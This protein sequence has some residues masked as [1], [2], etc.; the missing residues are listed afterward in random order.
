VCDLCHDHPSAEV[1]RIGRDVISSTFF[2][3]IFESNLHI[4][5]ICGRGCADLPLLYGGG[6]LPGSHISS[7]G[8]TCNLGAR[9]NCIAHAFWVG[10]RCSESNAASGAEDG[11]F[12]DFFARRQ[13][14]GILVDWFYAVRAETPESHRCISP[15]VVLGKGLFVKKD[16]LLDSRTV[17]LTMVLTTIAGFS[18]TLSL[19]AQ[20]TPRITQSID[21]SV[22]MRIAG[23]AHPL[24]TA[25]NDLGRASGDLAME[26]MILV[27]KPSDAQQTALKKLIDSQ[28]DRQSAGYH[29]WLAPEQYGAQF[30]SHDDD[31]KTV[32]HWL[33]SQGF[34][35][36]SVARGKQWI[37][38][39]GT[40]G[41]VE[42]AFH[43][44]MHHYLVGGEVH[45]ANA[46]D[47]SLPAALAPVV[48]GVL[49]L[50]DFTS[51]PLLGR[52]M[53]VH[54][55]AGTGKLAP[56]YTG[57]NANGTFHVVVPGDYARIYNTAPLLNS[58]IDGTGVSIAIVGRNNV[59]LSDLQTFRKMF[60]LPANDPQFIFNGED[61]GIGGGSDYVEATLDLEWAAAIAPRATIKFVP[62]RTTFT[63][64]GVALSS[65]YIVDNRIA[66]IMSSSF[67]ACEAFL[68]NAGNA[69][70]RNLYQ[71]AAA[72]GIS[73][74]VATGD[75]GVAGCDF[76]GSNSSPA[77]FGANVS[78]AASTPFDTAVGGTEFAENGL[79]GIYWLPNNRL[80]QSSATGYIPEAVWNESCDPTVD[81]NQCFGTG[82]YTIAGSGGGPSN[83]SISS[84]TNFVITCISGTPKPS[85]QAGIGVPNDG[86]R[87]IPDLAMAAAAGHDPLLLCIAGSCQTAVVGGQTVIENAAV[88]GGTSAAAPAMAGVMALLE[89][90]NGTFQGLANYTLY[91]LAAAENLAHC[92]SSNLTDPLRA[93]ACVFNDTTAGDNT[94]PGQVGYPAGKGYDMST[95]LGSVNATNLVS[96]WGSA[97]K[98]HSRSI[99]ELGSQTAKHG[100]PIPLA[101]LVTPASG[102]GAPSGDFSLLSGD[103]AAVFGGTLTSGAFGGTVSDLPGGHYTLSAHYSGDAM[104]SASNSNSVEIHISPEESV[105]NPMLYYLGSDGTPFAIS[106]NNYHV[107]Y[108][109]PLGM[110]VDVKGASGTGAPTGK[111]HITADDKTAVGTIPLGQGASGFNP[112][113]QFNPLPGPHRLNLSYS[114]DNSFLPAVQGF[115]FTVDKGAVQAGIDTY[116]AV[117]TE[118]EPVNVYM[119]LFGGGVNPTGTVDLWDNGHH[120]AGPLPLALNGIYGS[121]I[122]QATYLAKSLPVGFDKLTLTYS[123]DANYLPGLPFFHAATITV[124][125]ATGPL[126]NVT[127]EQIPAACI[128]GQSVNYV[129]TVRPAKAG[130]PVPTGMVTLISVDGF[131]QS[132]AIPLVNGNATFT[133][134]YFATGDFLNAASYSGDSNYSAANSRSLFTLVKQLTP[135]AHLTA[136]AAVVRAG[137]QTSVTVQV[138]GQPNNPNLTV[139]DGLVQFFDRV[140]GGPQRALGS[141]QFLTI[142][143]GGNAIYTM[144]VVL[145]VGT[146]VIR[147]QY[148]GTQTSL[149]FPNPNDWTPA[150]S[151]QVTVL[152]K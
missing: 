57:L 16:Q 24:A 60:L 55:D 92:N 67:G 123:G 23:S 76:S 27:L 140:N 4:G 62:S 150:S 101:L 61:P 17:I 82:Q 148:M 114:G 58:H 21:N 39:S 13:T 131:S 74:F 132:P 35:V 54:R 25:A 134:P 42:R 129:M 26:R 119:A 120:L 81:P 117:V 75:S 124:N 99:M 142:G 63:T 56:D 31:V 8:G 151:N 103:S 7:V 89:Q 12:D 1:P 71:Q 32:S 88:I 29:Q 85:W 112:V 100:Q 147:A 64:D 50:H 79:D 38:F 87:D 52:K 28:H 121:G 91:Q 98:L 53:T 80:D 118:G 125:A 5:L 139:P 107:S 127:F 10:L 143:N 46:S 73:V 149:A 44:E 128:V 130:G 30:G 69:F 72:E 18:T 11:R 115:S 137:Q 102:N 9:P 136:A 135:T 65:S 49:S 138:V 20:S 51:K 70:F 45:L 2:G 6:P 152:V 19:W 111:V 141:P 126:V 37:E 90:K 3:F 48:H 106:D 47:I 59:D 116:P 41:Q 36:G 40:S 86:V 77:V 122:P 83:C 14:L 110:Q 15:L 22:V 66:P 33:Q 109:S 133:Q 96:T 78:G 43:T 146:H 94:V 105:V 34:S 95:G 108:G 104:F 113:P 144:P 145:S 84:V 97:R 93:S 68:G